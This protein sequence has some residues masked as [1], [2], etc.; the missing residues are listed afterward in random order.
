MT[1]PKPS[2][3]PEQRFQEFAET[4]PDNP[5]K[6]SGQREWCLDFSADVSCGE[7]PISDFKPNWP[8]GEGAIH[9]IESTPAARHAEELEKLV[10]EFAKRV[11]ANHYADLIYRAGKLLARIDAERKARGGG[12]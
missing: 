1:T 6:P 4:H 7:N 5:H 11:D 12:E 10:L 2:G 3:S 8:G 9:V